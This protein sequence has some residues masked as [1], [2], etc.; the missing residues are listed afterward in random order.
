LSTLKS[1]ERTPSH[2]ELPSDPDSTP[3]DIGSGS[4]PGMP[5]WVKVFA[6]IA[7]GLVLLVFIL[8]LTGN[9]LH[10]HSSPSSVTQPGA[11]QP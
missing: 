1:R 8:H 5:R 7:I 10:D 4:T 2:G 6:I 9:S 3:D 11:H